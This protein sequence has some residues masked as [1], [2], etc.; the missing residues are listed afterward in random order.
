MS[1]WWWLLIIALALA[2]AS[3]AMIALIVRR[4]HIAAAPGPGE[5]D[6]FFDTLRRVPL[7]LVVALDLLDLALDVFAAPIVWVL[8]DRTNLRP[9]RKVAAVEA[10]IP[11][12]NVLPT[13]TVCWFI[14]RM[15]GARDGAGALPARAP[16]KR[17]PNTADA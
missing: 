13:M 16:R 14:A 10:L 17:V 9:L 1:I 15:P 8:L 2:A 3:T 6:G 7:G 5:G 4:V 12:T 11:F